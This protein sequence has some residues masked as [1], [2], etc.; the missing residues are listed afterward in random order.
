MQNP[1]SNAEFGLHVFKRRS[2]TRQ[3]NRYTI[4]VWEGT[5]Q[6]G[7]CHDACL[8]CA[9]A[10]IRREMN[11]ASEILVVRNPG[12]SFNGTGG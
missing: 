5:G 12:N 10:A 7:I 1:S 4:G 2:T 9:L 3:G 6:R 11:A 8:E